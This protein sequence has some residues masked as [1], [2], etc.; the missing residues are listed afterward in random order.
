MPNPS[1]SFS[2]R[3]LWVIGFIA[4]RTIKIQ[5]HVLAVLIT[6]VCR[7]VYKTK[8]ISVWLCKWGIKDAFQTESLIGYVCRQVYKTKN[9]SVSMCKWGLKDAFQTQSLIAANEILCR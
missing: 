6:Y 9:I 3:R 5:L 8:Y 7:Q 1:S 4:S 2:I